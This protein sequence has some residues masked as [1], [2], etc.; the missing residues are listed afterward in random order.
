MHAVVY[1]S[2]TT[3]Q[4]ILGYK[5]PLEEDLAA[6]TGAARGWGGGIRASPSTIPGLS[7]YYDVASTRIWGATLL[8]NL[9][10][11]SDS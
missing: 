8:V 9:I 1:R 2:K 11:F 10:W 5:I 4:A 7:P 6:V 3:N